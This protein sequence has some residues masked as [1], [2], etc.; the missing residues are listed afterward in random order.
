[1]RIKSQ[2][3]ALTIRTNDKFIKQL[4]RVCKAM[5]VSQRVALELALTELEDLLRHYPQVDYDPKQGGWLL[6]PMPIEEIQAHELMEKEE[7]DE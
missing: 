2:N 4:N 7:D 3:K 5:K 1:M 6:R